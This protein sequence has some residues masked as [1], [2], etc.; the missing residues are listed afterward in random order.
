LARESLNLQAYWILEYQHYGLA[1]ALDEME[2]IDEML[3]NLD[4]AGLAIVTHG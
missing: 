2:S 1:T 4:G 3:Q